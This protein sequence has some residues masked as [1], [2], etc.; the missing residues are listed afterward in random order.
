MKKILSGERFDLNKYDP[1]Y[2]KALVNLENPPDVLYGI[3]NPEAMTEGIAIVGPRRIS[4]YGRECAQMF[5]DETANQGIT[6]ISGG[7]RGCDT[8]A[9]QAALKH[10]A[11]TVAVLGGGCDHVYPSENFNLFQK[12]IENNGCVVSEH[13][14]DTEPMPWMFRARNRIVAAMAKATLVVEAGLPSGTYSTVD[15]ALSAGREVLAI[16][17]DITRP[18]AQG[19]NRIIFEGAMPITSLEVYREVLYR[20]SLDQSSKNPEQL[21]TPIKTSLKEVCEQAKQASVALNDQSSNQPI[22]SQEAR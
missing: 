4:D 3:G 22:K 18:Q 20:L 15:Y 2:P 5:A 12:I 6:I 7:A 8:I 9:H 17:G 13:P 1:T 14:F 16:P 10:N 19:T 21:M 11:P